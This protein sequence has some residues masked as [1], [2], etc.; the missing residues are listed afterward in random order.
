VGGFK[1]Q[2]KDGHIMSKGHESQKY[3]MQN[4]SKNENLLGSQNTRALVLGS[5]LA[6]EALVESNSVAVITAKVIQVFNLIET[7]DPVFTG[8]S[9]L[10]S[11]ELGSFLR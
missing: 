4:E 2:N 7:N 9:L 8:E 11:V 3:K 10:Q 5:T 6:L 1:A